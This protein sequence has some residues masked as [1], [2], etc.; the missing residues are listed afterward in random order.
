M[1]DEFDHVGLVR[2]ALVSQ[3][4]AAAFGDASL[5][6]LGDE[7]G[8]LL[9]GALAGAP[10][11]AGSLVAAAVVDGVRRTVYGLHCHIL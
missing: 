5:D 3:G 11:G 1:N 7:D 6:R 10:A 9:R 2:G 4:P 8:L